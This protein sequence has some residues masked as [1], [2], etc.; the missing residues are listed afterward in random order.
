MST[1][2]D[3]GIGIETK[4]E[5]SSQGK[6]ISKPV[7]EFTKKE[8]AQNSD[9]KY[10]TD[11]IIKYISRIPSY[12]FDLL[13]WPTGINRTEFDRLWDIDFQSNISP[14]EALEKSHFWNDGHFA[15]AVKM[16]KKHFR[17]DKEHIWQ[18]IEQLKEQQLRYFMN[19]H[20]RDFAQHCKYACNSKKKADQER[21]ISWAKRAWEDYNRCRKELGLKE[22]TMPEIFALEYMNPLNWSDELV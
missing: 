16:A 11:Y 22:E 3:F 4:A 18:A 6:Q 7:K 8:T 5:N 19:S 1:L 10:D 20:R 21:D 14:G 15:Y 9:E 2:L 13:G 12:T 17:A